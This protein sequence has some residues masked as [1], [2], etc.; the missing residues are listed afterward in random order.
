M[1]RKAEETRSMM[2]ARSLALMPRGSYLVNTAR[3]AGVDT[4]AIPDLIASGQLAGAAFD[5][6]A[7]EPPPEDD[8]LLRAWSDPQHPAHDRVIINP[9]AAFYCEQGINDMRIN[10]SEAIRRALLGEPIRNVVN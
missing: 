9:H 8:P 6:L 1:Q 4:S 3:G 7:C 5:V 10:G 2:N